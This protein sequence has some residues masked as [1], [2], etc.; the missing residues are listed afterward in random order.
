MFLIRW[1]HF[2]QGDL[3]EARK[4]KDCK[5]VFLTVHDIGNNHRSMVVSFRREL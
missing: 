4:E 2:F 3:D 5:C 1:T